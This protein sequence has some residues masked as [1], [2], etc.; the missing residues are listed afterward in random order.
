[1]T[2]LSAKDHRA[3]ARRVSARLA[4][5]ALVLGLSLT[6]CGQELGDSF[7]DAAIVARVKTALLNDLEVGRR[8]IEVSSSRGYVRLSGR[9]RSD[10][11]AAKA[12]MIARSVQGVL[13]VTSLLQ[14]V[15]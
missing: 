7:E 12:V 14:V 11:E 3:I 9:V 6:A 10:A 2:P 13:D 8:G 5:L 15:P 1:M 4:L